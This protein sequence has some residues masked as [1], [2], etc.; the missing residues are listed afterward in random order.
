MAGP[1]E[2]TPLLTSDDREASHGE[3]QGHHLKPL[4]EKSQF[5]LVIT[6]S[7]ILISS[8]SLSLFAILLATK[9]LITS[10]PFDFVSYSE[11]AVR[12][13]AIIVSR[14]HVNPFMPSENPLFKRHGQSSNQAHQFPL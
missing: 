11:E 8:L 3:S 10:G 5:K 12:I 1:S 9:V 14:A 4:P 6:V 13:L 2:N 7:R